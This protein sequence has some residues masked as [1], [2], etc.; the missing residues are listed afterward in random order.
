MAKKV[1]YWLEDVELVKINLY[2]EMGIDM[3][4]V[5]IGVKD[6]EGNTIEEK[7]YFFHDDMPMPVDADDQP[8]PHPDNYIL[9]ENKQSNRIRQI[10]K[11]LR[12]VLGNLLLDEENPN[13]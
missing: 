9:M 5:V 2:K 11:Q 3:I 4:K 1:E 13:E 10:R 6:G 8:I 12:N 7:V